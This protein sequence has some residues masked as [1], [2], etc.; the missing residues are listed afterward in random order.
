MR[1]ALGNVLEE[2]ASDPGFKIPPARLRENLEPGDLAELMLLSENLQEAAP[3]WATVTDV[4]GPGFYSGVFENGEPVE[5]GAENVSDIAPGGSPSMGAKEPDPFNILRRQSSTTPPEPDPFNILRKGPGRRPSVF[6]VFRQEPRPEP[7]P[8][9][10]P[11]QPA[12]TPRKGFFDWLDIFRRKPKVEVEPI[13]AAER[14]RYPESAPGLPGTVIEKPAETPA[15]PSPAEPPHPTVVIE[16]PAQSAGSG[17]LVVAP[18]EP[19]QDLFTIIA[20]PVSAPPPP[21]V[22]TGG[23]VVAEERLP[24]APAGAAPD[25]F[26]ILAPPPAAAPPAGGL[27]VRETDL[28]AVAE[29]L[30]AFNMIVAPEEATGGLVPSAPASPFEILAPEPSP[31]DILVPETPTGLVPAAPPGQISVFDVL[32]QPSGGAV[33]PYD[34]KALDP[35]SMIA[36][37][38]GTAPPPPAGWGGW[39]GY[40]P[41]TPPAAAAPS[42]EEGEEEEPRKKKPKRKPKTPTPPKWVQKN[43]KWVYPSPE[44]M[45][46]WFKESWNLPGLWETI[47]DQRTDPMFQEAVFNEDWDGAIPLETIAYASPDEWEQVSRYF[48]IPDEVLM[49]MVQQVHKLYDEG[50]D[51]SDEEENLNEFVQNFYHSSVSPALALLMP[52]DIPGFLFVTGYEDQVVFAY[53]EDMPKEERRRIEAENRRIAAEEKAQEDARKAAMRRIWGKMPTP[54][55][56][57]PFLEEKF[58]LDEMFRFIKQERKKPAFKETM[59][60]EGQAV[61]FLDMAA[62]ETKNY[63][64]LMAYYFSLPPEIFDL[65]L[66]AKPPLERELWGEVLNEFFEN[67]GEALDS[68]K[69]KALPGRFRVAD[70]GETNNLYVQYVEEP[71]ND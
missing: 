22:R 3:A 50:I 55:E 64:E 40:A 7:P 15:P 56:L 5:F 30:D 57:I 34:P 53:F 44:D 60:D 12:P 42:T 71:D 16:A 65:Y 61:I 39:G 58:D 49:P 33:A 62:D 8:P 19:P 14:R 26:E 27:V 38:P 6:Q 70:D 36:P 37:E 23:L 20:P 41:T 47:R 32:E 59:E 10:D 46:R 28:P 11:A 2:S 9:P 21:P 67:I 52:K 66:G 48:D 24:A 29:P 25:V 45:A 4:I 54:K 18:A 51:P 43:G 1:F 69:P 35:F 17:A 63:Y 68:L 31:F 13:P